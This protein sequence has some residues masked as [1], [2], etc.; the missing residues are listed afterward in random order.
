MTM[1]TLVVIIVG[2][3]DVAP[4]EVIPRW[5]LSTRI[6]FRFCFVYF[7]VYILTTQM[8]PAMNPFFGLPVLSTLGFISGPVMWVIRH[9]FHDTRQLAILGGS[10]DK[11]FDWVFALCL[12]VFAAA[13]TLVWSV[14]DRKRP[15]YVR[16][17]KWFRLF[18]R[19]A[20]ATTM[21]SYG[22]AKF[23]PLQMPAPSLTRLLEPY[24]NFSPMGVLWYSIGA[25][26]PYER[27]VG[28][29]ELLAAVLLFVPMTV[30]AGGIVA[31]FDSLQIFALNM[32][33]DVPVKLFSFHLIL[34]SL[35]IL[36]P[37]IPRLLKVLVLNQ[38]AP[39]STVPPLGRRRRVIQA[40]VALQI[41]FG[42]FFLLRGITGSIRSSST[43]GAGAPKPPLYG[44]WV[45]DRM[46]IDGIERAALVGDYERWRRVVISSATTISFWRMDDTPY[47][48]PGQVDLTAKTITLTLG[49]GDQKKTIGTFSVDQS[50]PDRLV[51]DG[52][53]NNRKIRMETHLFPRE[54]FLLVNRGFNW[55]QELPFNR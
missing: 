5:R 22:A 1:M 12:L 21:V 28:S 48:V 36:A 50:A 18:V 7:G 4:T 15:N 9:V 42:V 32:T 30:T 3:M 8:L 25:S 31:L 16:M 39:A 2:L 53:L 34:M 13:V 52:A 43:F 23:I 24:G 41:L 45:I 55:I 47:S 40:G 29:A 17:H 38:P 26:F 35:F 20:V 44:I 27:V 51:L 49:Q 33:Y 11:M 46:T 37:D 14:L 6:A 19:F 54:N 10:G